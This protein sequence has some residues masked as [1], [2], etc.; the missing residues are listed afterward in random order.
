M[1]KEEQEREYRR[2]MGGDALERQQKLGENCK[3]C[4]AAPGTHHHLA[5]RYGH[6]KLKPKRKTRG[7]QQP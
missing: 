1:D 4:G 2:L 7:R 5:C 3:G 6:G